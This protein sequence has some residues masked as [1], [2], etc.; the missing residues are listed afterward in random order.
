MVKLRVA[1]LFA[2]FFGLFL[3]LNSGTQ[4]AT[5]GM[6]TTLTWEDAL[7]KT[8]RGNSALQAARETAESAGHLVR[9]AYSGYF[10]QLT[11]AANGQNTSSGTS[12]SMQ[13]Q[14]TLNLFNGFDTRARVA[15]A[16][17]RREA[18]AA[19]LD[20]TRAGV[21]FELKSAFASL[22]FAQRSLKLAQEISRRR[23]DNV[24]IVELRYEAGRENRGSLLFSRAQLAQAAYEELQAAQAIETAARALAR[25]LGRDDGSATEALRVQGSVPVRA[26][27]PGPNLEKLAL[28]TPDFRRSLSAEATALAASDIARAPFFPELNLTG[29]VSRVGS[30]WPPEGNRWALGIGVSMNLFSGGKDYYGAKSAASL[31]GASAH[32]REDAV[33]EVLARLKQAHAAFRLSAEKLKV[34]Q[35]FADAAATRAEI[36]R[37]KYNNGLISF[38]DW[39]TIEGDLISRQKAFLASERDRVTAEAGWEQAQGKGV[40]P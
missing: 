38:E 11:G 13:L 28:E 2:L 15:Q 23:G 20:A 8:A 40:L 19:E 31:L 35:A 27:V 39:D 37:S 10:P 17:S 14:G 25:V 34:D 6:S 33:R 24:R 21:S 4:A 7:S 5:A 1:L 22:A 29:S 3:G 30:D 36:A 26:P 12:A 18:S 16:T 9:A 32:E